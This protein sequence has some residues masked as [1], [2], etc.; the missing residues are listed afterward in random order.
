MLQAEFQNAY[1]TKDIQA[2]DNDQYKSQS[3][4]CQSQVLHFLRTLTQ[5]LD[6]D[7]IETTVILPKF[8][9]QPKHFA[10]SSHSR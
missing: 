6:I 8:N 1:E 5:P 4:G 10:I 7:I 9:T 2:P 3:P